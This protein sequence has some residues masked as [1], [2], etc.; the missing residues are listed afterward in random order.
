MYRLLGFNSVTNA[1]LLLNR[2][3]IV[4]SQQSFSLLFNSRNAIL[5]PKCEWA[6]VKIDS[7]DLKTLVDDNV[8]KN[9]SE[10]CRKND[11]S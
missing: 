1:R 7:L 6:L 10:N 11:K 3:K 4:E 5:K 8:R 2:R 9:H